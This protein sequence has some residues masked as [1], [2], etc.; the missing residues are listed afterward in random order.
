MTD[1]ARLLHTARTRSVGGRDKG[2]ARSSDGRLDIKLSTPGSAGTGTNPEQLL[3]AGWSASFQ[4]M[5]A[6]AAHTMGIALSSPPTID[7]EIDLL[8]D[9]GGFFLRARFDINLPH[10]DRQTAESLISYAK[11]H[12]PYSKAT[13]EG[14]VLTARL[15][16]IAM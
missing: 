4:T 12:C 9:L 10:V 11:Q 14:A 16:S 7:A 5:I 3:A 2:S 8:Q 15:V 1:N 13:R 6:L